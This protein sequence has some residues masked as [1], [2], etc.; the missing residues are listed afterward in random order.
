MM[1]TAMAWCIAV[2]TVLLLVFALRLWRGQEQQAVL[3]ARIN[4]LRTD[5]ILWKM[6]A[7]QDSLTGLG[8]RVQL[9]DSFQEAVKRSQRS[10]LPF[11][12]LMI[13]LNHFKS[14][15]DKYGHAV[16]DQVL[17]TAATRLRQTVR[18]CDTVVRIGGDE[19]VVV[20]ESFEAKRDLITIGNK[21]LEVL[22][23]PMELKNDAVLRV[24]AS[25]GFGIYPDDAREMTALL[26]M[27][28]MS[29][30]SCKSSGL[31]ELN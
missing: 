20:L 6:Q 14:I 31:M 19:F 21:L 4:K 12:L 1:L 22:T 5:E 2:Q 17:V 29:M 26:H 7:R 10:G 11:A 13:D 30:Y 16:G 3:L 24:G 18:A 8:N 9:D 27:A 25:V 23:E 15:N 28:D